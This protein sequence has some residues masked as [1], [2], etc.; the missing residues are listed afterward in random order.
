MSVSSSAGFAVKSALA[1]SSFI[2][3]S[4]GLPLENQLLRFRDKLR[5][6]GSERFR[7]LEPREFVGEFGEVFRQELEFRKSGYQ[8]GE[9]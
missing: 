5:E 3:A 6:M 9:L 7:E 4:C 1:P 2:F 8:R